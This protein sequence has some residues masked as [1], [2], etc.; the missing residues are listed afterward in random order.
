M[1]RRSL[2]VRHQARPV[3]TVAHIGIQEQARSMI[4]LIAVFREVVV[5]P[6]QHD[7]PERVLA[8]IECLGHGEGLIR[9]H[10]IVGGACFDQYR[11]GLAEA[12]CPTPR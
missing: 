12:L 8:G 9:F 5:R 6:L 1:I 11:R 4:H 7:Q 10:A 3:F 2:P